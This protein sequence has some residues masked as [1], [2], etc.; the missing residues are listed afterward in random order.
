[1]SREKRSVYVI[2]DSKKNYCREVCV[3]S[4][5]YVSFKKFCEETRCYTDLVHATSVICKLREDAVHVGLDET[6]HLD[7]VTLEDVEMERTYNRDNLV[8][9][10]Y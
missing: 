8:L 2:L 10:E 3:K 1:L 5:M 6:F 7:Y 9:V 4:N